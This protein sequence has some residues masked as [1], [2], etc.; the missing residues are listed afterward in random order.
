MNNSFERG[1]SPNGDEDEQFAKLKGEDA[2]CLTSNQKFFPELV[3]RKVLE[4]LKKKVDIENCSNASPFCG[5]L[6]REKR[7]GEVLLPTVFGILTKLYC[8]ENNK[9]ESYEETNVELVP[10]VI[11]FHVINE[12][13]THFIYKNHFHFMLEISFSCHFHLHE[14]T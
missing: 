5:D 14:Y 7:E 10:K 9:D 2:L 8:D 1:R 13:K 11:S 3:W 4:K 6:L 12:M